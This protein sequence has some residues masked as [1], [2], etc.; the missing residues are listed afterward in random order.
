VIPR[1]AGYGLVYPA[2]ASKVEP[3]VHFAVPFARSWLLP[4]RPGVKGP[5][6]WVLDWGTPPSALAA[7][8][9]RVVELAP[10]IWAIG[11]AGR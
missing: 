4:R 7:K 6:T 2:G 3:G 8:G 5:A 11:P 1:R 9:G 10:G